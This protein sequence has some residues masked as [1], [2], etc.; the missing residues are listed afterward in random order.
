MKD[1]QKVTFHGEGVQGPGLGPGDTTVLD[2][3]DHACCIYLTRRR[4]LHVYGHIK[5]TEALCGLQ[6][7]VSTLD[8]RTIDTAWHPRQI[9]KCGDSK[10]ELNEGMQ[11]YHRPCN[12]GR[13]IIENK[14]NFPENGFLLI[15]SLLEKLLLERKEVEEADE[16]DQVDQMDFAPSQER[17]RQHTGEACED[18]GVSPEGVQCQTS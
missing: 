7:P 10:C 13:L 4:P 3:K 5:V 16:M 17:W 15:N 14:V 12:K 1:G 11:T 9:F 8:N 18:D 2:Q 6:M